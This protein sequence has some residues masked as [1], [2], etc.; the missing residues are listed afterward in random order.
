MQYD[1]FERLAMSTEALQLETDMSTL[2]AYFPDV[3]DVRKTDIAEDKSGID[4]IVTVESGVEIGMDVK[5]REKGC[6]RYWKNGPE[7]ALETWSQKWPRY[8]NLKN[9][10]GWTV[11]GRKRCQYIM[12]KFDPSDCDIVYIF[13]FWQLSK[14]FRRN[15]QTW[16]K[17][18]P[19]A[20]QEQTQAEY[21][22]E[23]VFV[24]ANVV[25]DAVKKEFTAEAV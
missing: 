21:K 14:A 15:V 17:Q 22:S 2:K 6:S 7:L 13:P 23:C 24:P 5:T 9:K 25:M 20:Y 8:K 4:Y 10:V 11:D 1:F 16:Y 12:F 18:Y 3:V 19:H